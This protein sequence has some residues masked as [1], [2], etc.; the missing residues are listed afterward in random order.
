MSQLM[1]RAASIALAGLG[2]T[3]LLQSDSSP[4]YEWL[5]YHVSWSNIAGTLNLPAFLLAALGSGNVHAPSDAW[6]FGCLAAQWLLYGL[7]I[8]WLSRKLWPNNSSKPTPLRG[9][10]RN[11]FA[12]GGPA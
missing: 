3:W 12:S 2:A 9:L 5:L 10:G 11:R 7:A 4:L 8:G 6:Y 1:I